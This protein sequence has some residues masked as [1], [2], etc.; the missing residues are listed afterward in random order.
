MCLFSENQLHKWASSAIVQMLMSMRMYTKAYN[1]FV[2]E[3]L[4]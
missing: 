2:S 4:F 1:V 3:V